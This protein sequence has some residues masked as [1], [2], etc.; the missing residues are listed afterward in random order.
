MKIWFISAYDAPKGNSSRTYDYAKALIERGHEVTFFTSSFD[1]FSRQERLERSESFR[2]E[3]IDGIRVVWLKTIPYHK[4][5][6]MRFA[7]MLSNAWRAYYVGKSLGYDRPDV[8]VGPS[9]PLFT[10]LA[11]YGLS[12]SNKCAFCFE[13]RDIWPQALIDLGILSESSPVTWGLR[14]IERFLYKKAH[15]IVAVLPFAHRHI[16]KSGIDERKITWLPNGVNFDR[17]LECKPYDGGDDR[18]LRVMYVGRFTTAHSVETIVQAARIVNERGYA[19]SIKFKLVGGGEE[20]SCIAKLINEMQLFNVELS[21]TVNKDA[22]P[23]LLGTADLLVATINDAPVYQFGVNLNKLY[24]YLGAGR[25]ILFAGNSPNDPVKDA[26]AGFTVP[27]ENPALFADAIID[28]YGLPPS[29]RREMGERGL[30]YAK[31]H[32]D[33]RKLAIKLESIFASAAGC[34]S[35]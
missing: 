35:N 23:A 1:H 19:Q 15:R 4:S 30:A 7:N 25:P 29:Q 24:D 11:A 3:Y 6:L 27:P 32:F 28:V 14:K 17:F 18:L 20:K 26:R 2:E 22:I 10:G 34:H 5:T 16:T 33:T 31:E 8:I 12:R 9:V 21:D 13:V